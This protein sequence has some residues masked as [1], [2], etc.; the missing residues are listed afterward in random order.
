MKNEKDSIQKLIDKK[1]VTKSH[2][3]AMLGWQGYYLTRVISSEES[4]TRYKKDKDLL[5]KYLLL[6]NTDSEYLVLAA[7]EN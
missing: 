6:L 2:I 4:N 1:G 7:K 5:M 3:A